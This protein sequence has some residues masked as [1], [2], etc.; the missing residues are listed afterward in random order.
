[1]DKLAKDKPLPAVPALRS[2]AAPVPCGPPPVALASPVA[3]PTSAEAA[4]P[5]L[6]DCV[7]VLT[8]QGLNF[9]AGP[10]LWPIRFSLPSAGVV[11]DI[12][13]FGPQERLFL[14]GNIPI[15]V[16]EAKRAALA[17]R[18]LGI[19]WSLAVGGFEM[20]PATGALRFCASLSRSEAGP[21]RIRE[22][23]AVGLW[24]LSEHAAGLLR[25]AVSE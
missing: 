10:D 16:P 6:A 1:M 20:E 15:L 21:A 17:T 4:D 2:D 7:S 13:L 24:A 5:L 19:N 8:S 22:L 3:A 18:I 11:C 12:H 14:F 23:I 9:T 25:C